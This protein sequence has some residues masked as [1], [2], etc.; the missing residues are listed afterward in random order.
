MFD[1]IIVG[2]GPAGG[3]AAYHLAKRGRN[4]LVVEKNSWPRNKPCGGGVSPAIASWF[5]F[6]F[7]PA[8]STTVDK[9]RYTFKLADPAETAI[10]KPMWMVR[11]DV[12][13][14]FLM[15][16]AQDQGAS[17]QPNTEVTGIK[18][19]GDSW[20]LTTAN[21]ETL[22]GRYLIAADGAKGPVG[23]WLRL[24]QSNPRLA[25]V[26]EATQLSDVPTFEFGMVKNGSLWGFPKADGYTVS[27]ATFRGKDPKNLGQDLSQYLKALGL[28][29]NSPIVEHPLR[30]WDGDRTLHGQNALIAGEAASIV[31]PLSGE[32][33]RPAI[34]TGVKAAEAIDAAIGGDQSALEKYTEIIRTEWGVDMVWASR[35]AG[36]FYSFPG[37]G[38]K[39]AVKVPAATELMSKILC[40]DLRYGDVAGRAI[41]KLSPF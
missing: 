30:L 4:P 6:D 24:K 29:P 27:A 40:G 18:F 15:Q 21:G 8:I 36:V 19:K 11:R 33:I 5:D 13:D 3:A 10:S 2:A 16:Q 32:G 12:F 35:L 14:A 1:C 17:F 34:L 26:T 7:T 9:I 38:Y 25:M 31:D 37:I 20:Q 39:A 41:K 28:N 22:T 23:S